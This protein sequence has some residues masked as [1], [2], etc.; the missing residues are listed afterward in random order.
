ME[1]RYGSYSNLI[2]IKSY[3]SILKTVA[4]E[5]NNNIINNDK[6]FFAL[7]LRNMLIANL[8][9][10]F[11]ILSRDISVT[12]SFMALHILKFAN[13]KVLE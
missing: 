1:I 2:G 6:L 10:L 8:V 4:S 12:S 13:K 11:H 7:F 5:K 9:P 3:L